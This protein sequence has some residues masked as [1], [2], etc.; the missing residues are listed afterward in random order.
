MRVLAKG[1]WLSDCT[2][3]GVLIFAGWPTILSVSERC[4]LFCSVLHLKRKPELFALGHTNTVFSCVMHWPQVGVCLCPPGQPV[5]RG[6]FLWLRHPAV[7]MATPAWRLVWLQ[8]RPYLCQ[9]ERNTAMVWTKG[10]RNRMT[11]RAHA[12]WRK[13]LWIGSDSQ[14]A[15]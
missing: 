13:K 9:P 7:S 15:H 12:A 10:S 1:S 4:I 11:W 6:V 5:W 14:R 8:P 3:Y 2:N